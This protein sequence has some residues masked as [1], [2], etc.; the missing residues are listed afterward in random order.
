MGFEASPLSASAGD[1]DDDG[2]GDGDGDGE[3]DSLTDLARTLLGRGARDE[4]RPEQSRRSRW[5]RAAASRLA[6]A[7]SQGARV[8]PAPPRRKARTRRADRPAEL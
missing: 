2:E 7:T 3:G 5:A 8:S 6:R 4:A 1:D